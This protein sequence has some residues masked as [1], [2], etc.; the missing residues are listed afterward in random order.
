MY[1]L[2]VK[3]SN[4]GK[5]VVPFPHTSVTVDIEMG[6]FMLPQTV[7]HNLTNIYLQTGKMRKNRRIS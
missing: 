1:G 4:L 5:G 3:W 7:V 6:T 2:R